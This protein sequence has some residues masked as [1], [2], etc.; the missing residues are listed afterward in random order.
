MKMRGYQQDENLQISENQKQQGKSRNIV[1]KVMP[2]MFK[3]MLRCHYENIQNVIF[4]PPT[5]RPGAHVWRKGLP[6]VGNVE[7]EKSDM[8]ARP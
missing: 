8:C 6:T 5:F 1:H 2:L 7:N 3:L 4:L